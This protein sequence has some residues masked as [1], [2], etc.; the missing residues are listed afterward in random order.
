[1]RRVLLLF[2][3]C[4]VLY[5]WGGT[6]Y[7]IENNQLVLPQP[8]AFLTH[9]NDVKNPADPMLDYVAQYLKE[10]P[11]ITKFRIESHVF[12]ENTTAEN[13]SLSLQR[14]ALISFYLT[15]KGVD[16]NRLVPV[17]FG[18]TKPVDSTD[19]LVNTRLE[20]YNAELNGH[21]INAMPVDGAAIKRF[22]PCE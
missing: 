14:A 22:D 18:D 12:T 8:V 9:A 19:A 5:V 1:M 6:L 10:K 2:G 21:A 7:T 16:C 15:Q 3:V 13:L 20:F 17:G 4:F 11:Y